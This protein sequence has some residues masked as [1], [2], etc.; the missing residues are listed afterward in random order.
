MS[1]TLEA[2]PHDDELS[3]WNKWPKP[4]LE[5]TPKE[6]ETFQK[7]RNIPESHKM[8]SCYAAFNHMRIGRAGD[9]KT[10]CFSMSHRLWQKGKFGLRD[11]W[12]GKTN[13]EHREEFLNN[14][15]HHGCKRVCGTSIANKLPPPIVDYDWNYG[16]DR[17]EHAMDPDAYPKAFDLEISNLCN[18]A[19]PMCM[20]D[21]SSKHML[22][23]DKDLKKYQPNMFDD[24]ENLEQLTLEL[25][26]FIPH[27]EVLRFTGGEPFAHK[28]FYKIAELSVKLNPMLRIEVCTNGS[29]YNTKVDKYASLLP[30][31]E[32]S[33][34]LD[35]VNPEEYSKIRIG[36]KYENTMENIEKF[37]NKLGSKNIKIN[38]TLM[39]VNATH[40]DKFFQ[41][42]KENGYEIFMNVYSRS[43]REHTPDWSLH[44][45]DG[46][47]LKQIINKIKPWLDDPIYEV[48]ARKTISLL[49][50]AIT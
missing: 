22:G 12:F 48:A 18:M 4:S 30:N 36:G 50:Q 17:L 7:N 35:T 26:E 32:I 13:N 1:S 28:A 40:I 5:D 19:C 46:N 42:G 14:T 44:T 3:P 21:L 27:L 43:A 34:S 10:C 11:W 39:S 41:Y 8:I 37:K 31:L 25:E 47:K 16:N 20:G 45:V 29:I 38:S 6:W 2:S 9:M 49:K 23:R 33:V 15:I 24:D